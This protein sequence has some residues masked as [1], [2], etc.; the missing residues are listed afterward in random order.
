LESSI[1]CT[2]LVIAATC[3]GGVSPTALP[4]TFTAHK[5]ATEPL[6]LILTGARVKF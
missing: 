6:N 3:S 1:R 5:L 2:D 4:G